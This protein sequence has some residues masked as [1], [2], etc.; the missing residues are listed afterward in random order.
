MPRRGVRRVAKSGERSTHVNSMTTKNEDQTCCQE[1]IESAS[2]AVTAHGEYQWS[3]VD[4][5]CRYVVANV[6]LL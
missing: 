2:R 4:G 3:T 6:V 5:D 1:S